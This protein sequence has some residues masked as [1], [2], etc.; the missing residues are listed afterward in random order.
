[1]DRNSS[2][3]ILIKSGKIIDPIRETEFTS[4]ILIENGIVSGI[5]NPISITGGQKENIIEINADGFMV[6]PGF[7]DLH[8]HMRD[9]GYEFKETLESGSM[10]AARGGVTTAACMPNT[11]PVIDSEYLVKYIIHRSKDLPCRI[12]P[13]AAM[14]KGLEGKEITE[15]GILS[16]AG[17]AGFS[18]D[19]NGVSDSKLMFEIMRYSKQFGLPLIL[20]EEDANITGGGQMHEGEFS[21]LLGLEGISSLSEDLMIARDLMLAARSCARI[22]IT[23]LSTRGGVEMIR[24]AKKEGL[25]VTCDVTPH[26]L[27]FNDSYLKTFNTSFKVKP[28]LRSREDQEALLEGVID[29]TIDAIASDHAPHMDTEKNTTFSEA[30]FGT[31]GL[32]TLFSASFTKLVKERRMLIP[33]LIKL[34]TVS[35][36]R[37]LDTGKGAITESSEADIA[38]IDTKKSTVYAKEGIVSKSTNSAF[39]GQELHGEIAY[40][41]KNG[42]VVYRRK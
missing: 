15:M 25:N 30:A 37:I 27:F 18:D 14:T 39:I 6:S 22:H 32:E 11:R 35:P 38:I 8:V 21:M 5:D 42:K 16:E 28:P 17:A 3:K 40:T 34:I 12:L 7:T 36:A 19:G 29:G 9:P 24:K 31:I 26:H 33:K 10:A 4:D 23:H 2:N 13:V 1:M 41:I 20:H